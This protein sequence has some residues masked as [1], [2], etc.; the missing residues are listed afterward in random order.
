VD[1]AVATLA[2][3]VAAGKSVA[4]P[5]VD[6][7]VQAIAPSVQAGGI[8]DVTPAPTP[9]GWQAWDSKKKRKTRVI[10]YSDFESRDA[11]EAELRKAIPI[12]RPIVVESAQDLEDE[13]F[14]IINLLELLD[15]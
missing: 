4:V 6:V 13:D 15:D 1:I 9:G 14:I 12:P 11:Y 7:V 2:P 3:S 10:R 5:A 8:I